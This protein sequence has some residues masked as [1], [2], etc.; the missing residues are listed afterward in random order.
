MLAPFADFLRPADWRSFEEGAAS[1]D[2][3]AVEEEA[4]AVGGAAAMDGSAA[5]PDR[6]RSAARVRAARVGSGTSLCTRRV[7]GYT[8]TGR[9]K[10]DCPQLE[11][12]AT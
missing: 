8:L 3:D 12:V 11:Q 1:V 10:I 5:V 4:S 7:A 2:G 6:S 9:M